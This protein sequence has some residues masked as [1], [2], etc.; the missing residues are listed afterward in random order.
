MPVQP[1]FKLVQI[2]K[3]RILEFDNL[4]MSEA[5]CLQTLTLFLLNQL[6]FQPVLRIR[7][8]ATLSVA[9]SSRTLVAR[10]LVES[11]KELRL[12]LVLTRLISR[13][14]LN[15]HKSHLRVTLT[16]IQP[17]IKSSKERHGQLLIS[18]RL[19]NCMENLP[20]HTELT[21]RETVD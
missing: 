13:E 2:S 1:L 10:I 21:Q 20:L 12:F 18:A 3:I 17:N 4:T 9:Q 8:V 14:A 19:R 5:V 6:Q 7:I 15:R 11:H 16:L